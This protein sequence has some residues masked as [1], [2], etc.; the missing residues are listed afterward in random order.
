MTVTTQAA[1]HANTAATAKLRSGEKITAEEFAV[2]L[3]HNNAVC[4]EAL[5]AEDAEVYEAASVLMDGLKY[6]LRRAGYIESF[7]Q[8]T[9]IYTVRNV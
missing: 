6:R 4:K 7:D 2:L 5:D 9:N 1:T 8:E 3:N